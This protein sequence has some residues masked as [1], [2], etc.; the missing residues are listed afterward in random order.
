MANL[1]NRREKNPGRD[2]QFA[3]NSSGVA[4]RYKLLGF[5]LLTKTK[6]R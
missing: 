2:Q 1:P 3:G 6:E 5:E 4:M